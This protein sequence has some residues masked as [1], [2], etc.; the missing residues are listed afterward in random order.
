M[1][2]N[3]PQ[4]IPEVVIPT[5]LDLVKEN[6]ET[7]SNGIELH[8]L[9]S[10]SASVVRLSLVFRGGSSVQDVPFAAASTLSMLSEGTA[11]YSA[12]EIAEKLDFYGIFFDNSTDRDYCYITVGSL[13]KFLPEALSLLKS[14]LTAPLFLES[15]LD[16]YRGKKRQQLLIDRAKPSFMAREEFAKRLFGEDNP[17]GRFSPAE[18]YDDLKS[19]DLH[20]Y[21]A[22]HIHAGNCFAICSGEI[23]PEVH[24]MIEDMLNSLSSKELHPLD[25]DYTA[26]TATE[27]YFKIEREGSVQ[28]CIRMGGMLFEKSHPD[29]IPM[30][31][32]LTV[33]GGYFGSRLVQNLR[34]KNGYT[35]GAFAG[36]INL[37]SCGYYAIA[38]DV[39]SSHTDDAI[40]EIKY[41]IER[42]RTEKISEE[43][44]SGAVSTI[45]GELMRLIDGPFGI[46]DIAIENIQ[47][48]SSPEY[49]N[50][51]LERV[52][53]LT[54]DDLLE[55]SKKYLNTDDLLTVVVG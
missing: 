36:I 9:K 51:F 24:S 4:E 25:L 12:E 16:L 23:S 27:K 33:L 11:D 2:N 54:P 37:A 34:E 50:E 31:L 43:E 38:T 10:D 52:T 53:S 20:K 15:E 19:E 18:A 1:Q 49:L 26:H 21:F 48:G 42:L 44:L 46:A 7:L 47:S 30:Q 13:T 6:I 45:T 3:V 5:H 14:M 32:V 41:E 17:Y 55:V 29:F 40:R 35:Y 39:E 22:D 28:S 8:S